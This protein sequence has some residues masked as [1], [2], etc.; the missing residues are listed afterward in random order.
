MLVERPL[1]FG[2]LRF[3]RTFGLEPHNSYLGGFANGGWLGGFA[4]LGLV[5]T[6]SFVGFRL[7][8]APSPFQ[9]QAQIVWPGL[10]IFFL[11]SFQIDVDHWRH[12]FLLFGMVWGM[13]AARWAW[14]AQQTG[15][16]VVAREVAAPRAA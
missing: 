15:A 13:E 9:R 12:V 3:R 14:R 2:P 11:Q 5:L 6:T 8:F 4:F 7:C 1:G 10:M 16:P